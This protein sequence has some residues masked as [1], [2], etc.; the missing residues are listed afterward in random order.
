V[1]IIRIISD[2][3]AAVAQSNCSSGQTHQALDHC[4]QHSSPTDLLYRSSKL[5]DG[6]FLTSE[7]KVTNHQKKVESRM[8]EPENK[9]D[10][11]PINGPIL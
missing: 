9:L 11:V 4:R 7:A 3:I 1:T 5:S 10:E 6:S 2:L 8:K